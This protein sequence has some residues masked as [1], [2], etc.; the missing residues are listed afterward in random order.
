MTRLSGERRRSTRGG[1]AAAWPSLNATGAFRGSAPGGRNPSTGRVTGPPPAAAVVFG[2]FLHMQIRGRSTAVSV[3]PREG[4]ARQDGK[5][6]GTCREPGQ[7]ALPREAPTRPPPGFRGIELRGTGRRPRGRWR[8]ASTRRP[9]RRTFDRIIHHVAPT[10]EPSV[11]PP[12]TSSA[13]YRCH[14]HSHITTQRAAET[15][16]GGGGGG[17]GGRAQDGPRSSTIRFSH[18][19]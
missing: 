7:G 10:I 11:E 5:C 19:S 17:G 13:V 18:W 6:C 2:S 1:S 15:R 16:G 3:L 8:R 14:R 4:E 12:T 9:A